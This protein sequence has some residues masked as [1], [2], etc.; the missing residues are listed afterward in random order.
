M[1]AAWVPAGTWTR[2]RPAAGLHQIAKPGKP[3]KAGKAGRPGKP[4][5]VEVTDTVRGLTTT[6]PCGCW[7]DP[8]DP[9]SLEQTLLPR[10]V[11]GELGMLQHYEVVV[12]TSDIRGAGTDANISLELWG[13]KDHTAAFKLETSSNNFERGAKDLFKLL[14]PDLG[15]L[16][17]VVVHKA[18]G[19]LLG[20]DW[21]LQGLEVWHPVLKKRYFMAC[22]DWLKGACQR[23]LEVGKLAEGGRCTYR[24]LV[25]TSDQR[26][27]GTDANVVMTLFG[28]KGDSGERK[29]DSSSNDFER[30]KTDTFFFECPDVGAFTSLRISHDN[31]GFA[32]AWH[33]AKVEVVNT[34][35]GEQAVFPY[36]NWL[37]KE[38]GLSV[39]L[40]PD[41]DGDGK[42]DA[43]VDADLTDYTVTTYTSDIRGAGTD[44][45]V[46]M[47]MHGDKGVVGEQRL[48]NKANNFERNM[49]D[50]FKIR[51][52]NIGHVRKVVMRHD[53]SGAFSD[54]HLQQVEVFSAA[55]N[56]TY[57][58]PCNA[59]LRKEGS[60]PAGLRKE[61]Q[62]GS[63][64]T[65]G[66]D[67][68]I[69]ITIR[70]EKGESGERRLDTKNQNDFERGKV[71]TFFLSAPNVGPMTSVVL[72]SSGGGLG[73]AWH[74]LKLEVASSATGETLVFPWNKWISQE[75]GLQHTLWPD[76]DGDGV[77]DVGVAGDTVKYRVTVY[78]SDLRAA[79]TDAEVF[80]EMQG[81][82]AVIGSTRLDNAHNNFERGRKDEF[83]VTGVDIGEVTQLTLSH[84]NTGLAPA[85]HL[86]Q[87]EVFHPGLQRTFTFPC[88]AWLEATKELG[89]EGCKRVLK[90]GAAAAAEGLVT[91]RVLVK[92]SDVRGAG[93]DANVFLTLYGPKGDSGE[94]QIETGAN[95]FERGALDTFIIKVDVLSSATNQQYH[96]PFGNWLDDK[97]GLQH[98][99]WR[100]G[101]QGT[102]T[103]LVD[104][105]ITVFTSDLRGA[106]TDANVSIELHGDNGS[107]GASRLE[108]QA[109]NFERGA[110]DQ[111]LVKGSDVGDV[112]RVVISHDNSG[113]GSAWH[114]QQV[115]V[116]NPATQRSYFFPCNA[117]LEAGTGGQGLAGCSKE[118][119]P[120]VAPSSGQCDYKVEVKTSDLRG[121]GTDS[122][123]QV[124]VFGTKGDT[125]LR[126]LDD[127]RDNFERNKLDVFFFRA[128]D[129]GQPTSVKVVCEGSGLAAAWHLA[130]IA[131]TNATTSTF[132]KFVFNNWFDAANGWT[133]MLLPEGSTAP[134]AAN[135]DYKVTVITSDI[136]GAG[137]DGEV[138]IALKGTAGEMGETRLNGGRDSF[139]RNAVDVFEITGSDIGAV[140]EARVRLAEKGVG[141]AW[142]FK[143]VEVVNK[144]TG[145][146]SRF[147]YNQWLERSP[148][149]PEATV[150]LA[151][152]SSAQAL[153][154][155]PDKAVAGLVTVLQLHGSV[156]MCDRHPLVDCPVCL[157]LLLLLLPLLLPLQLQW[158][159]VTQT[160]SMFG[161]GTDAPVFIQVWGPQG[162]LGG[163]EQHLDNSRDNFEAGRTD[164][165]LLD[166][167]RDKDCGT[168]ITRVRAARQG[169]HTS[170]RVQLGLLH[171]GDAMCRQT[172]CPDIAMLLSCS[173]TP[174]LVVERAASLTFGADWFL[175]S[176]QVVDVSRGHT[177]AWRCGCWFNAKDGCRKEWSAEKAAAGAQQP[178][179]LAEAPR[180]VHP[181]AGAVNV[182]G[183]PYCLR[184]HTSNKLGAGTDALVCVMFTDVTGHT[185][186][187][188][189]AQDKAQFER[190]AT[191]EFL[192]SSLAPLGEVASVRLWLEGAGLG[193]AWHLDR[194]ILQHL[195]SQRSWEFALRDW[196]PTQGTTIAAKVLNDVPL[197]PL[198]PSEVT[199]SPAKLNDE[200]QREVHSQPDPSQGTSSAPTPG[201]PPLNPPPAIAHPPPLAPLRH[202][203]EYEV[204]VVTGDKYGAGTD[205][206]VTLL[207]TGSAGNASHTLEQSRALF[208]RGSKDRF[209]LRLPDCG[210]LQDVKV[211]HDG[212]GFGS[213]WFLATL[214]VEARA[215][216]ARYQAVFNTWLKGGADQGVTRPL[217]LI[218]GQPP[219]TTLAW[220]V[221]AQHM[222]AAL[223]S[224][225]TAANKDA[226]A[227]AGTTVAVAAASA[228]QTAP[229]V[230]AAAPPPPR[231]GADTLPPAAGR[232]SQ[233]GDPGIAPLVLDPLQF[234]RLAGMQPGAATLRLSR[235]SR[236]PKEPKCEWQQFTQALPKDPRFLVTYYHNSRTG[237]S[238][239]DKPAEYAAWEK[240]HAE[241]L[242]KTVH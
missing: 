15:E 23:K 13:D 242:A 7:L 164:T 97:H 189:L 210:D 231:M 17:H 40:T 77:A 50:V 221:A 6:F 220:S 129:I 138:Y 152:A 21:H 219:T 27:A 114:C 191:D 64:D 155:A 102:A 173:N 201:S 123:V 174:Q 236:A 228:T 154:Q 83:D 234:Q 67:A 175:D 142:H 153:A 42:G 51:S 43:L 94:R 116:F 85:W 233:P 1:A 39:L 109:N 91:Y 208:E 166:I 25:T 46:F 9:P 238:S 49:K 14:A 90:T 186:Q 230:G 134:Q 187:P 8:S 141:A 98:E 223:P 89:L 199:S 35:T 34:N 3:G 160:G 103:P 183:D 125:G 140:Q 211:S 56:K 30:G 58:F 105:R 81:S 218:E 80:L 20:S 241:Y 31:S 224:P 62:E 52:T 214:T 107:V 170:C 169:G 88:Q 143:E 190:A 215:Y 124:C 195:P 156:C 121:A 145:A 44:A 41:R 127:S 22:N 144:K 229:G 237:A 10:G 45:T 182:S 222:A 192:A 171:A 19:G 162:M 75:A 118:L 207:L 177:Y 93:T 131:V 149:N 37:D 120:G 204:E 82:K 172:I 71:D 2:Y 179:E 113:V 188:V 176:I 26:G 69:F 72:R 130:Y 54:W 65:S 79:G 115:E 132:A 165:F 100:D 57:T 212:S 104:Y 126:S 196:L 38:H 181:S 168:P 157:L 198:P 12:Y 86:D 4:V 135:V 84:N 216:A 205:S 167:P 48:D 178:L 101:V 92:T 55:T 18:S 108:T 66:T 87:V 96:F 225:D 146:K 163:S 95:N 200:P 213:D 133:Q 203:T 36:H 161:A 112:T 147:V 122:A 70:G 240:A 137:T 148:T 73:A 206:R 59:W 47:E 24:V 63:L 78:T 217:R 159:V 180:G 11:G 28:S 239:Y 151:E 60:D 158:K 119:T 111:F 128:P 150:T 226:A 29:L 232:R 136:R 53:D 61:L 227:G 139:S 32:S 76:R 33:L 74:L 68:D 5:Q 194:L 106:G 209:R 117:W 185:W 110:V 197:R 235:D 193:D 184:F 99:I 16:S 202:E